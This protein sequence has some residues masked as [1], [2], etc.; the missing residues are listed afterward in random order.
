MLMIL[1]PINFY[2]NTLS[3]LTIS[4]FLFKS[5]LQRKYI[6]QF[7]GVYALHLVP[8]VVISRY[9]NYLTPLLYAIGVTVNENKNNRRYQLLI[10]GHE[11]FFFVK[12]HIDFKDKYTENEVI[13]MLDF[14]IDNIF[15]DIQQKVGI[16]IGTYCSTLLADL[17][18]YSYQ[19]DILNRYFLKNRTKKASFLISNI[20]MMSCHLITHFS[21]SACIENISVNLRL[22]ILQKL[23][24]IS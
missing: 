1:I 9:L 8:V 24:F 12:K 20:F 6:I 3:S 11:I 10:K 17:F 18:L 16:P 22:M 5:G 21:A 19:A 13:K 23:S 14:L 15:V 7:D 2:I 4:L